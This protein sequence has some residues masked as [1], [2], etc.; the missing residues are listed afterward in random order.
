ML[1]GISTQMKRYL[2]HIFVSVIIV[3]SFL[4]LWVFWWE[5]ASLRVHEETLSVPWPRP[6]LRVAILT[7]LHIGSPHQ[8]LA[9]LQQI[10]ALINAAR[11]DLVCILG[12]LVIHGV[13]GGEFVSP[14]PIAREL[15]NLRA[16]LGVVAVLGNHD[17]W[18]DAEQVSRALTSNGII[19]LSDSAMTLDTASDS[20]WLVGVSDLWA[21][22]HDIAAAMHFVIDDHPAILISHNPDIFPRVPQRVNLTLAGHTHGGQVRVPFIGAPVVPANP[23]YTAGHIVEAGKHLYVATGTGTSI[24]PVRFRVPPEIAV[25]TI[26][27][28]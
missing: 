28:R 12:D 24:L 22:E 6:P 4:G 27:G 2:R 15:A 11:P 9:K 18:L 17:Y 8:D 16:R 20:F 21:G 25:V 13:I 26:S 14:E 1:G 5:P 19:V 23:R 10:V 7:D 3:F